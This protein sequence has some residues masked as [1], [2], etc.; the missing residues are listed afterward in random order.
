MDLRPALPAALAA[1]LTALLALAPAQA[2]VLTPAQSND[3]LSNPHR[4]FLLWGTTVGADGGL[5]DNHYGASIYQ[6]YLPWREVETADEHYDWDGFEQRHLA[7][8]LAEDPNA[9][10]VL[11]PVADYP[12]SVG[13]NIHYYYDSEQPERDYPKF[14]G[15]APL[16]IA[17]HTY[18]SCGGDGPGVAPDYNSPAMRE[19]LQQFVRAFARRYDGDPRITAVHVGLLG[20]WGEWHTSG[21]ASYEPDATTRAL[22]RDAYT[23]A[24]VQTP[25]HTRYA[26][27]S[28]VGGASF[29]FSEDFFPSFT[30]MCNA[31]TPKLKRCDDTGWWNL[32][33][34]YRNEVPAARENWRLNPIG[35]ES[36]YA[37]QKKLWTDR[38]ADIV[39]MVRDYHFTW[40]GPA[41]QH[42]NTGTAAFRNKLLSIKRA[43]GYEFTVRRVA[44]ADQAMAGTAMS[45]S[46]SIE[47]TGVAPLYQVYQ[48]ELHWLDAGGVVRAKSV[49]DYP[50]TAL[51]PGAANSQELQANV[52]ATLTPGR[53]T[54]KLALA[55]SWPGRRGIAPQNAG[56]DSAGRLTLGAVDVVAAAR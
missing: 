34:G 8:I 45:L 3:D 52:P 37:D 15:Q 26:R 28:D 5:P 20:F 11:R 24:F 19:Q 42:E 32:E 46:L 25:L 43:L 36:P 39:K 16:N 30:A 10:F 27:A 53:Y 56:R 17:G 40:L 7:P 4:G 29:G 22:V 50:L 31:Y 54:L 6:I 41:G 21:C 33:W 51:L 44:W 2:G 9:T 1:A 35:G 47:N 18:T 48:A 13:N 55:D 12:D 14:L 23:S 49:L 38:T